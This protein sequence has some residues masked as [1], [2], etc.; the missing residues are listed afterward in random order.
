MLRS[1]MASPRV[2]AYLQV[3]AAAAAVLAAAVKVLFKQKQQACIRHNKAQSLQSM[4]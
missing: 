4:P 3:T 1:F 2:A